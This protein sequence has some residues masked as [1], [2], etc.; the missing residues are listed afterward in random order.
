MARRIRILEHPADIGMEVRA[1]TLNGLFEAS[2]EGLVE[3]LEAVPAEEPRR[4]LRL[5]LG[6]RTPEELLVRF[7]N[8]LLYEVESRGWCPRDISVRVARQG[9]SVS[10]AAR[11]GVGRLR[12]VGR[13]VKAATYHGLAIRSSGGFRKCRIIFD[14]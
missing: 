8:E 9:R 4:C 6:A 2:A 5:R 12:S 14:L 10:L 1:R 13:E 7:L 11:I 3:I